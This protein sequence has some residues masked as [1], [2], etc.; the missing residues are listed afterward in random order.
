MKIKNNIFRAFF[1]SSSMMVAMSF[2]LTSCNKWLDVRSETEAKEEELF[3]KKNGFCNAL[4]GIYI[5][6]ADNNAYGQA[7]TMT[8][9]EQLAHNWYNTSADYYVDYY[10]LCRHQ[11]ENTECKS[12]VES[13][14]ASLFN[15]IVKVNVLIKNIEED[16]EVLATHPQLKGCIEGEAHALKALCQFDVL[17]I[18]G[19]LP[20]GLGTRNVRLPYSFTT[21][22]TEIP[23][24]YDYDEYV[25]LLF[26]DIDKAIEL[27]GQS[28][29]VLQY[30][31]SALSIPVTLPGNFSDDYLYY[32]RVR[33]NYWAAK[34]L[35]ARMNLYLGNM[36]AAHREALEVINAKTTDGS[37]ICKLNSQFDLEHG[38]FTLPSEGLFSLSKYNVFTY[39]NSTLFGFST[40]T[41][42]P[43]NHLVY[44][45]AMFNDLFKGVNTA[46][47]NRYSLLW[48]R[49]SQTNTAEIYPALAKYYYDSSKGTASAVYQTLI[50]MIRLSEMYLIAMETTEDLSE[51]NALYDTYMRDRNI[52]L[53]EPAFKSLSEVRNEVVNEYRREFLAEG[54]M[55]YTYK[56]LFTKNIMWQTEAMQESDYIVPLPDREYEK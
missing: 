32:R 35:R 36:E 7:L 6:L 30:T 29:P 26:A 52:L 39:A 16:T 23:K 5:N 40:G 9:I 38:Y 41:V 48:N 10:Y 20:N 28:D 34:A 55:F 14:Y 11:Y 1:L 4:T 2:S 47:H 22:I 46:S 3:A 56:R 53:E 54:H 25:K 15:S 49:K 50:P 44:S 21:A 24:Y 33:M 18:F 13:V 12:S 43:N 19:Q 8:K 42:T 51:A 17:R 37:A 45:Q 27:L 31:L